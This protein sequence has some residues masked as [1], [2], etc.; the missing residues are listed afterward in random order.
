MRY[1]IIGKRFKAAAFGVPINRY[2]VGTLDVTEF[3]QGLAEYLINL[4]LSFREPADAPYL[5]DLLRARRKR[6]RNGRTTD[7]CDELPSPHGFAR[8]EDYIG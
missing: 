2:E 3:A 6:P 5:G 8:A 7:K 4:A 1:E